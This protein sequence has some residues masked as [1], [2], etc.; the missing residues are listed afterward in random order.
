MD[1]PRQPEASELLAQ[2]SPDAKPVADA[3]TRRSLLQRGA[4]FGVSLASLGAIGQSVR[5]ATANPLGAANLRRQ[6]ELAA[7]QVIR[8]AGR[9]ASP[10]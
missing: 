7:V 3:L 8:P 2:L 1:R 4:A 6:G 10:F 9:R 5:A